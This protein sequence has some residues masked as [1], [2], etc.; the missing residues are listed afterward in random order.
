MELFTRSHGIRADS[1]FLMGSAALRFAGRDGR[2]MK[3]CAPILNFC[4][5]TLHWSSYVV[6]P[7]NHVVLH[8]DGQLLFAH[9]ALEQIGGGG[10]ESSAWKEL[11]LGHLR[12]RLDS[13]QP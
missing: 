2:V 11:T 12:Y 4:A 9:G 7:W 5:L 8:A 13:W 1:Q 6:M 3:V 10:H